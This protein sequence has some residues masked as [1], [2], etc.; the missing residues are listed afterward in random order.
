M[1]RVVGGSAQ[2]KN[3]YFTGSPPTFCA[4][5]PDDHL[6]A[7]APVDAKPPRRSLDLSSKKT[8]A[9][10][11]CYYAGNGEKDTECGI[12]YAANPASAQGR[13]ELLGLENAAA[14]RVVRECVD[15]DDVWRDSATPRRSPE[16]SPRGWRD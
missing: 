15:D 13:A 2:K 16:N 7:G 4:P 1:G 9:C 10:A 3:S 12:C 8:W 6:F 14:G 5:A 11:V